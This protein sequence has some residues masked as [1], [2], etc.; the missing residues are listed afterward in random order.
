MKINNS[1][2]FFL[3]AGFGTISCLTNP[4]D[5]FSS[6]VS[7]GASSSR[8]RPAWTSERRRRVGTTTRTATALRDSAENDPI[9]NTQRLETLAKIANE[10][11]SSHGTEIFKPFHARVAVIPPSNDDDDDDY[12]VPRQ[13]RRLG[14]IASEPVSKADQ[15]IAA[16]PFYDSD[17]SG[18][19]L[20]P[21]LATKVVYKDVLPEGYDGWT[22]DIGLLAMLLL[23]EMARLHVDAATGDASPKGVSDLPRR[24]PPVQSLMNA[25]VA[26]LPS[27]R[28]MSELH[29][30]LWNE[31]EQE[32]LQSSSTKKIY[33]LL[34]D[35]DDDAA[36]L[37][38]T[39]WNADRRTFPE[40]VSLR[41]RSPDGTDDDDDDDW[42]EERPCFSPEGFRYAVALVRSRS[43]FVDGSLRLLPFLDFA[44]HGDFDSYEISG[45]GIG[46]LWGSAK[47]AFLKSG[48]A[49]NVGEEVEISYGPKGPAEYLLDHGF[50]PGMCR[51]S[52]RGGSAITAE[53]TFEVDDGDRFRDDKLD[54]L[55]YETY[56]LAPMDPSQSFDV[57]GGVGST[58]APDPAMIQFLRLVKLGGRDAFLLESIF[59]KEV[60]GFMSEPVSEENER[61]VVMGVIDACEK[62]LEDM[63]GEDAS[64]GNLSQNAKLC[65]MVR[66]SERQALER[67][68]IYMKQ[69]SEALDLKEYYQERRLKSLGLDSEWS[70]ED[71][72]VGWGGTRVPGGAD[73]D[74]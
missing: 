30:L 25:Y 20:A 56:D 53:L 70:P 16:I 18:L 1:H 41:I 43:F 12:D 38:E 15:T 11:L 64:D 39:L 49:L 21:H 9:D 32:I 62:A 24:K 4:T 7:A 44:N 72:D 66:E 60:W 10:A 40:T 71:D 52:R 61:D 42:I 51:H 73:Y 33:R 26:A 2:H 45:G 23:N 28:E 68:L 65:A 54:V 47:G 63:E 69:E 17:G 55:E 19:A 5:G 74:W 48:K 13:F 67:T 59:R 8:V 50:V 6:S 36:W 37:E 34:D 57:V 35:V 31:E 29:P 3:L 14:L 27:H 58:G 46:T 22:G